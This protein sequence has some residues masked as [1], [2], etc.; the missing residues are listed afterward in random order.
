MEAKPP[1]LPSGLVPSHVERV[2]QLL[3]AARAN[4]VAGWQEGFCSWNIGVTA[5]ALAKH[6]ITELAKHVSW[7]KIV[8]D[9]S[10]GLR[11]LFLLDG[12]PMRICSDPPGEL[13]V[14]HRT[15]TKREG[16]FAR[17]LQIVGMESVS[18]TY[19][20]TVSACRATLL[21]EAVYL[22]QI[23]TEDKSEL[24]TWCVWTAPDGAVARP[25]QQSPPSVTPKDTT[26]GEAS[27]E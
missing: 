4:A 24:G 22:V 11:L 9:D 6:Y 15:S 5:Y 1:N 8:E 7:C 2:A 3:V 25:D 10:Q 26:T 20:I 21:A 27:G 19:R 17:Q 18:Y 12:E 23:S 14:R 16:S 13:S